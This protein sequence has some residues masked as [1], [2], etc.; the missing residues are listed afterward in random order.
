MPFIASGTY[1][2]VFKPHLECTDG[3]EVNGKKV[4]RKPT[5]GKIFWEPR[6]AQLEKDMQEDIVH[7][8]DPDGRFSVRLIES[9]GVSKFSQPTD[10]CPHIVDQNS[11]ISPKEYQQLIYEY[12][13]VSLEEYMKTERPTMTKLKKV[14]L[15]L[16]PLFEGIVRL[17]Y[18]SKYV[19]QDIKPA[20]ILISRDRKK[21]RAYLI[22]FGLLTAMKDVYTDSNNF[23]LNYPYPFYPPEFKLS[24]NN[25][26]ESFKKSVARNFQSAAFI[27]VKNRLIEFGIDFEDSIA[28]TFKHKGV[29]TYKIDSYALGI[30]LVMIYIWAMPI[31]KRVLKKSDTDRSFVNDY[32]GLVLALCHQD[33]KKRKT[34]KEAAAFYKKFLE[35]H[36]AAPPQVR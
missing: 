26:L 12:G 30:V 19:H 10:E 14:L 6:E 7:K 2:C 27:S 20:N 1:G 24:S 3:T 16:V 9:C 36:A 23:V 8:V 11:P 25:S 18:K 13:G 34:S 31:I 28:A 29:N 22:D 17:N 4:G 33:S 32:R 15:A 21:L 5:V 35:V